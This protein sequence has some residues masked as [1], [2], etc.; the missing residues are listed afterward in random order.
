ME[1]AESAVFTGNPKGRGEALSF[2]VWLPGEKNVL[3]ARTILLCL[4]SE[5]VLV[6]AEALGWAGVPDFTPGGRWAL[7]LIHI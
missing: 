6:L 4:V 7:S 3:S 2:Q 1:V 5:A